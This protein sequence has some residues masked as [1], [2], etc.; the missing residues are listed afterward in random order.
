MRALRVLRDAD[1]SAGLEPLPVL[2]RGPDP[3]RWLPHSFPPDFQYVVSNVAPPDNN[4]VDPTRVA[5]DDQDGLDRQA[6]EAWDD[7]AGDDGGA[8]DTGPKRRRGVGDARNEGGR[9]DRG[10]DC[11]PAT[12]CDPARC[13]CCRNADG[14]PAY[15]NKLLQRGCT[16][17]D[18]DDGGGGSGFEFIREC[19]PACGCGAGC[20]NRQS[21]RGVEVPLSLCVVTSTPASAAGGATAAAAGGGG[22]GVFT[23]ADLPAGS[24]VCSYSGEALC[25]QEAA[26]RLRRRD[27]AG[28]SNYILVTREHQHQS[29]YVGVSEGEEGDD[30]GGDGDAVVGAGESARARVWVHAVDPTTRGNVGRWLNHACDGGNLAPW[31]VRSAGA[32]PRG[33]RVVFF[34]TRRVTAGE[35]LRWKYGES[36]GGRGPGKHPLPGGLSGDVGGGEEG[37]K[38]KGVV[39]RTRCTCA[40][41]ACRGW[42][43]FD[44]AALGGDN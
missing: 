32:G 6:G 28:D 40:T 5:Q 37:R 2:L 19:G 34:T 20:V 27:A 18:D 44:A 22:V 17:V 25:A 1:V 15:R 23:D 12:S 41:D 16:A 30:N 13:G 42:M 3:R 11:P 24:L 43:P 26:V 33:C 38:E 21:Q 39:T 9:G 36:A 29:R 4:A 10:C 14:L 31:M 7:Q 35:E 8:G